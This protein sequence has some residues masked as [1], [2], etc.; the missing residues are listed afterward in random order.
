VSA[1]LQVV[2][3]G[4]LFRNPEPGHRAQCAYLPNVV[5]ID[6]DE[7]VCFYR[8]GQAFYSLDGTI[9][10]LRSTD[11]GLTWLDEGLVR[12]PAADDAPFTYTAPHG[13]RLRDGSLLLLA[14]RYPA[15][16]SN[17]IRF[18]PA[19]GGMKVSQPVLFR[20]GDRGATWSAPE[21]L[22]LG[23]SGEVDTP[24]A[25]IELP[26]GRWFLAG[27]VWKAWDDAS[28]L[29]IRGFGVFSR[30]QGRTWGDRVDFP[31]ALDA[32]RMYSHSRYA[33]L[34]D[35]SVG[36]LQW[37]QSIGGNDNFDLHLVTSDVEGRTWS[38]P[39]PTGIPAQ[40]SWLADLGQNRMAAA[41]TVREGMTPGIAVALSDD[42]GRTWDLDRQL[43][44]WDAVGQEYL[45]VARKPSYPASHDN[46]AFGK[47]NLARLPS[48]DLIVAWW[49]TQ[50]CVTH[51]RY[52]RL[53]VDDAQA[54]GRATIDQGIDSSRSSG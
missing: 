4:V 24:S 30:D 1:T 43:L 50:A 26:D 40:T 48:G 16:A 54:A 35:G 25:I 27:E 19:T 41:Y 47:P 5:P 2:H 39:R 10:Q 45:G 52:A 22:D 34:T 28:P 20:A 36:A 44:V 17:A 42:G 6:G 3:E 49:C 11:G 7:L 12:D 46:I 8:L 21:V 38:A 29:H 9:A 31:S 53:A 32:A 23:Q 13:S 51:T 14:Q 15:D 18:N 33:Q 37:T